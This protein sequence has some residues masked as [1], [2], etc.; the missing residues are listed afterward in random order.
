MISSK[1]P[2]ENAR[3]FLDINP[4]FIKNAFLDIKCGKRGCKKN[5]KGRK[6]AMLK[7]RFEP[8]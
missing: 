1:I 6:Q 4:S 5:T 2:N 8:F 7:R 3:V